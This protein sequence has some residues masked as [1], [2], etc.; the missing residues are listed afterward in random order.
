MQISLYCYRALVTSV[1]DG[2][3]CTVDIDLGLKTWLHSEKLRLHRINT[4]ELRGSDREAGL[5]ARDYLRSLI[6]KK[7]VLLQTVEDKT[8]KFGRYL[9]E[10][11]ILNNEGKWINVNDQMIASG[12]AGYYQ[13]I[14]QKLDVDLNAV[15]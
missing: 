13:N 14:P 1:Y 6:D 10:L 11:W 12:H 15:M 5:A 4:P 8:G 7:E 9:A 2:D 3:T